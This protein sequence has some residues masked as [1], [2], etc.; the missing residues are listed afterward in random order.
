MRARPLLAAAVAA[1]ALPL[2]AGCGAYSEAHD[3]NAP[4]PSANIIP[5]W[6]RIEDPYHYNAIIRAC[7]GKDGIYIDLANDNSVTVA[8]NDPDCAA[9]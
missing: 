7:V 4:S 8:A 1:V 9:S 2:L 3:Y 6:V 5:A